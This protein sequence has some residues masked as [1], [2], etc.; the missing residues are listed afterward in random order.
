[1]SK[2]FVGTC[3]SLTTAGLIALGVSL[4]P[5][6]AF[7]LTDPPSLGHAVIDELLPPIEER[8]PSDPLVVDLEAAGKKSGEHG[9][10]IRTLM[11]RAKDTRQMTVYGYAR[12]VKYNEKFE[13][14]PDIVKSVDIQDGRIFTFK[15]RP[16]HK[17][18]DGEPFTTEDFRYWWEDVA[19]NEELFPV[20]PPAFMKVRGEYPQV[21]IIDETTVRYSWP[22][23]NPDFLPGLAGASPKY[24]Y[25]PAH[26]MRQ[27]HIKYGDKKAIEAMVEEKG[28][29]SWASIHTKHGRLYRNDNPDLP[30]L[31]P[32][33][34]ETKSPSD[35][36]VFGR[37]PFYHKVDSN[38]LQ[39]PY[40]DRVIVNITE[41]KLVA[42][43]A[44]TGDIDLQGRYLR[45]DDFTLLK[46]NEKNQDYRTLLWRIAKGAHLALFPNMTHTDPM[47]RE[48]MRSADFRRALSLAVNRY[49]INRVIYFG[50]ALEGQNTLL[51]Q[52]PLFQSDYRE[53]W[54]TFDIDKANA[55]LDGMGLKRGALGGVRK[56]PNGEPLELIIETGG[57]STEE[58]DVL[59]LITDSWRQIGVKT[60]IKPL[61]QDN[62]RR[63]VFAGETQMAISYGW[64]NGLATADMSP[65]ELAPV[66]Q[67]QLQWPKWGQ[68][69]E[70]NGRAGED[71]DLPEAQ[72]LKALLAEWYR[73]KDRQ[74]KEKIWQQM[75]EIHADNVFSIGLVAG[76]LQPIVVRDG[77]NNVPTEGIWNWDPGAHFGIYGM[78]TF[79][80]DRGAVVPKS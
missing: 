75:L 8:V 43:K 5:A 47:W 22:H 39:L 29:R 26:Y 6:N 66:H 48:L 57:T 44:A 72:T 30:V 40:V 65:T 77:L 13:L 64:D 15:L 7:E 2:F 50:L 3:T 4:A 42:G 62:L 16:G 73:A 76:V 79:W 31:Q 18:S 41:A 23:P 51:P 71:V 61:S 69:H 9:G 74:Q 55:L 49:E 68:F 11:T 59:Q 53:R 54:S 21:D 67:I 38:G 19:H 60:F 70:T 63:R 28:Q 35:R 52:S 27:F 58:T 36:F 17:W 45:F 12:L 24:I 32:W 10:D 34:V 80:W 33:V 37:N 14:V 78:D 46:Q 56:L 1:M 25:A 20:G